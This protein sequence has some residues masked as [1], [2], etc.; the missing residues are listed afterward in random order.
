LLNWR[1]NKIFSIKNQA[2]EEIIEKKSRFIASVFPINSKEEAEEKINEIKKEFWDARHNVYAYILPNNISK[3]SDDGEPQGTAGQ[4]ALSVLQNEEMFDVC[5]VI[6]RYFGGILLG[7]GGLV[8]A[9]SNSAALAIKEAKKV[10][11]CNCER[12]SFK[13]PYNLYG[14]LQFFLS[15]NNLQPLSCDYKENII[16]EILVREEASQKICAGVTDLSAGQITFSSYG[17]VESDYPL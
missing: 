4:P 7:G 10:L 1:C 2:R 14:K 15:S 3:F 17:V 8:R 16:V 12:I 13:V 6:T 5:L 11:R 9:Y